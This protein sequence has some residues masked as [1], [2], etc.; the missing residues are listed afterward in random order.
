VVSE[1]CSQHDPIVESTRHL[2]L[3]L[4][5][6]GASVAEARHAVRQLLVEAGVREALVG[7]VVLAC[8][9]I[10]SNAVLHA[11]RPPTEAAVIEVDAIVDDAQIVVAVRDYGCGVTPDSS[12]AGAGLGL[13]L[14]ASLA[15]RVTIERLDE[16]STTAVTLEFRRR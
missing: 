5:A 11:Y 1:G 10:V 15:T 7:D 14:T 16:Q 4:P 13:A 12:G 8:N 6:A 3:T 2:H 9:E